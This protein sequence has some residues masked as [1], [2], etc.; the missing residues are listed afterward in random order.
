[1]DS[2]KVYQ[3]EVD[4]NVPNPGPQ[5]KM[6][7][8]T[9]Y[10]SARNSWEKPNLSIPYNHSLPNMLTDITSQYGL[11]IWEGKKLTSR[12]LTQEKVFKPDYDKI[13]SDM[14]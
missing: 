2:K 12:Q 1:L 9:L 4:A 6:L 14:K 3:Y 11:I 13:L 5:I 7:V 8:I 10:K